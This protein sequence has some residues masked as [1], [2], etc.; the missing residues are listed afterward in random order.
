MVIKNFL[1]PANDAVGCDQFYSTAG[2]GMHV[3]CRGVCV[4]RRHTHIILMSVR[5]AIWSVCYQFSKMN[6]TCSI[7]KKAMLSIVFG[8]MRRAEKTTPLSI[9]GLMM[10]MVLVAM[11][12]MRSPPVS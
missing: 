8:R 9:K 3:T 5:Q 2:L 6:D 1:C 11:V 12:V 4:S 10:V 7:C